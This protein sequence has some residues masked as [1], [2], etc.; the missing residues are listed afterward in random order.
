MDQ[1]IRNQE[2]KIA[3]LSSVT[4]EQQREKK[5]GG[6]T[7]KE[8]REE[9]EEKEGIELQGE[10]QSDT[11]KNQRGPYRQYEDANV[12]LEKIRYYRTQRYTDSQ[13]MDL[14]DNMPRRTYY[15]YVKKLQEQERQITEQWISEHV[16]H[17]AEELMIYRETLCQK[18]REVQGIIDNKNTSPKDKMQAIAQH[19]V[20]TEKLVSFERNGRVEAMKYVKNYVST[21]Y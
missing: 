7:Q 4:K 18:L 19:L 21:P 11:N 20:I 5:P 8:R 3:E 12:L 13:I 14:L 10:P 9:M 15:N 17:Y 6:L 16:E 2:E 1:K